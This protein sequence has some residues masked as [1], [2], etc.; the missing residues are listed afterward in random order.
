[1][2]LQLPPELANRELELIVVY[3]FMEL[4]NQQKNAEELGYPPDFFEKT[5]G[6]W[7]GEIL[8]RGEQGT[9]DEREWDLL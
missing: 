7:Q 4:R 1:L 6:G 9:C 3:Q 8:T 5:A 2:H